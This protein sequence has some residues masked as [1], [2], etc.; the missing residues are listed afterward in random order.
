MHDCNTIIGVIRL[1]NDKASYPVI[2][3]RY[4]IGKSGIDLI[5]NRYKNSG[6]SCQV[7]L[8]FMKQD[9]TFLSRVLPVQENLTYQM[10]C[11]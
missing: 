4:G 5:M 10:H 7:W 9:E 6:L 11:V 8:K 3:R 1:R 2:R